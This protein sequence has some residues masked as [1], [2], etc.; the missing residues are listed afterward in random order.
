MISGGEATPT[1]GQSYSL[2]CSVGGGN[3]TNNFYKWRKDGAV[4]LGQTTDVFSF[5]SV[6]LSDGGRYSCEINVT[7]AFTAIQNRSVIIQSELISFHARLMLMAM[8]YMSSAVPAPTSVSITSIPASPIRPVGSAVTLSC[9]V[10]LSP[11]VDVSVT[12]TTVWTGPAGFM[13]TTTAQPVMSSNTTYTSTTMV[14]SFGRDQ[15]GVYTCMATISSTSSF[16]HS[17][18]VSASTRVTVGE[19]ACLTMHAHHSVM[20]QSD[21]P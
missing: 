1:I 5:S 21:A 16:I 7:A 10:M 3:V 6:T 4:L 18:I 20:S 8:M 13:T 15:S 9:T 19:I 17:S 2:T 12:V 11:A 14:S